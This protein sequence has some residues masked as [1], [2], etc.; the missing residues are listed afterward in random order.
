MSI[1]KIALPKRIHQW[2][3]EPQQV[4]M[5]YFEDRKELV[6]QPITVLEKL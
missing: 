3:G 6:I 1:V 5:R 4:L 2:M